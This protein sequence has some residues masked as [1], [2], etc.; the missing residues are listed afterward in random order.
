MVTSF[1]FFITLKTKTIPQEQIQLLQLADCI[2]VEYCN[3]FFV[4]SAVLWQQIDENIY[5]FYAIGLFP[6]PL[7]TWEKHVMFSEGIETNA[8]EWVK[9]KCFYMQL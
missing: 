4:I 7:K 6:Y 5:P 2:C 9:L 3:Y 1:C 8:I